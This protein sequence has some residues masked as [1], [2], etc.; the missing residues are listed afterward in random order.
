MTWNLPEDDEDFES[1]YNGWRYKLVVSEFDEWLRREIKYAC[2]DDYEPIR[3]HLRDLIADEGLN[4][5]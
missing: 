2:K 5:W 1:A 4:I 3:E